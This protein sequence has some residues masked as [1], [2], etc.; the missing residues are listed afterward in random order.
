MA[1]GRN[2]A[3]ERRGR[4]QRIDHAQPGVIESRVLGIE[5]AAPGAHRADAE[6]V[7]ARRAERR[8]QERDTIAQLLAVLNQRRLHLIDGAFRK[9]RRQI[10][11]RRRARDGRR[12][13]ASGRHGSGMQGGG[14]LK[15]GAAFG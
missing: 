10:A 8:V 1:A 12:R 14:G 6:L 3:H 5:A 7:V 9:D 4:A 13:R 2:V 11:H 15:R